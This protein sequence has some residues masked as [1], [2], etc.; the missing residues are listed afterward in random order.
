MC[1]ND[2]YVFE[3]LFDV[4]YH[5]YIL[6]GCVKGPAILT[7]GNKTQISRWNYK[8]KKSIPDQI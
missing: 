8:I 4:L 2:N 6:I 3:K 1:L 7:R 5:R